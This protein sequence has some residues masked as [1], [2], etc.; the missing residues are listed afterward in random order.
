LETGGCYPP[1]QAR[2]QRTKQN[3]KNPS[4]KSTPYHKQIFS[5]NL[6]PPNVIQVP[7]TY[8]TFI[9]SILHRYFKKFLCKVLEEKQKAKAGSSLLRSSSCFACQLRH[10]RLEAF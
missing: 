4:G 3:R 5:N 9:K 10:Q 1:H 2:S 8:N 7:Y 6:S